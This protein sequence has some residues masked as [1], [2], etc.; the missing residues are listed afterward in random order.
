MQIV[1]EVS[2]NTTAV[3]LLLLKLHWKKK[4][5]SITNSEIVF[6]LWKKL[7]FITSLNC[8]FNVDS[9]CKCSLSGLYGHH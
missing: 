5:D 3:Q 6:F 8:V 2:K 4:A 7:S 9:I 1:V